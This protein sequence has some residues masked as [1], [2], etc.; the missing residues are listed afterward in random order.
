[1]QNHPYLFPLLIIVWLTTACESY[2]KNPYYKTALSERIELTEA[3]GFVVPLD[4]LTPYYSNCIQ[5]IETTSSEDTSL[6]VMY[7]RSRKTIDFYKQ[8]DSIVSFRNRI[9]LQK[10]FGERS[11]HVDGFLVLNEDSVVI[12]SARDHFIAIINSEG[13]SLRV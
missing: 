12:S 11:R 2:Q 3:G 9:E 1:M 4:S 7:N 10:T 5:Y 8:Q 13:D 6:L